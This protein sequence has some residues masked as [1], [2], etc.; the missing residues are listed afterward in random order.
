MF[1]VMTDLNLRAKK[2]EKIPNKHL[3]R[4]FVGFVFCRK[5]GNFSHFPY[6]VTPLPRSSTSSL[7][8]FYEGDSSKL[9]I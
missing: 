9:N 8:M 4:A 7:L 6:K 1:I 2:F 3:S 5:G